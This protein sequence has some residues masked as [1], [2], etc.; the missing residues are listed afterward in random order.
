MKKTIFFLLFLFMHYACDNGDGEKWICIRNCNPALC[1]ILNEEEC[2]CVSDVECVRE[3]FCGG[4]VENCIC[5]EE[6]G[7]NWCSALTGYSIKV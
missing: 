1:L 5:K 3:K 7:G 4:D 2:K 6:D